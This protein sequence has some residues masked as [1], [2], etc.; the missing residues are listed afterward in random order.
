MGK[1][2]KGRYGVVYSTDPQYN[3]TEKET[4]SAVTLEPARQ[5]LRVH[6]DKKQRGGKEVTL[7]TGFVGTKED[8]ESLGKT[9]KNKCGTGGSAKD[10][11]VLVQGNQREK[12]IKLLLE[13][14]FSD[15][16]PAGG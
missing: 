7:V 8:L 15:T 12:V 9:L 1:Q 11:E 6:L 13:M 4:Y 10:G 2:K 3:Y 16:K 14:G 5:K